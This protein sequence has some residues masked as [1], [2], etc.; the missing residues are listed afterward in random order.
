[1][2]KIRI[3]CLVLCLCLLL[4]PLQ[5]TAVDLTDISAVQGCH[6]ADAQFPVSAV[7]DLELDVK[8]AIL[9]DISTETMV[10]AS[11]PDQRLYPTGLTAILTCLL[12]LEHGDL[13]EMVEVNYA[14]I[15]LTPGDATNANLVA[16]E[17]ISLKDL[18]Y[19]IML[20]SAVDAALTVADHIGG[21][22]D[23]FVVMM[24][25]KAREL[26]CTNSNFTNP[27]GLHDPNHYSTARDLLRITQE[28]LKNETFRE[29]YSTVTHKIE[30]TNKSDE[31]SLL[32]TNFMTSGGMEG[33]YYDERVEGGKTGYTSDA[34]RCLMVCAQENNIQYVGIILGA[35][36][37]YA[38]DEPDNTT[39]VNMGHFAEMVKLL[40]H[41]F[42]NFKSTCVVSSEMIVGQYPVKQGE[43][44]VP[45]RPSQDVYC[46]LPTDASYDIF[47]LESTVGDSLQAPLRAE[48]T[49]G[50]VRIWYGNMCIGNVDLIAAADVAVDMGRPADDDRINAEKNEQMMQLL[51]IV[52]VILLVIL[53]LAVLLLVISYARNAA[54]RAARKARRRR[55]KNRTR[56]Q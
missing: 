2:K 21:T 7:S 47:R 5:A 4:M 33:A 32:T 14:I 8:A 6:T 16:G 19:C 24:N 56:R 43:N 18:L 53:G 34:G 55:R 37:E 40:T 15:E 25:E 10:Y 29:I 54:R 42:N 3:I 49:I 46:V 13:S 45:V 52:I 48:Q 30:A 51:G 50:S 39:I 31:R 1:M 38:S 11:N 26:G 20:N 17:L 28:A 23:D 22:L 44:Y 12:A 9:F 35:K 27:T 36:T 41:G